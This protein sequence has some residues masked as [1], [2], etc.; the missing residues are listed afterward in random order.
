M[1]FQPSGK[2]SIGNFLHLKSSVEHFPLLFQLRQD[3]CRRQGGLRPGRAV[4]P[5]ER[6]PHVHHQ[7]GQHARPGKDFDLKGQH[8][9]ELLT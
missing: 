6:R 4:L 9:S 5:E 7:G 2:V 3:P 1:A 8:S